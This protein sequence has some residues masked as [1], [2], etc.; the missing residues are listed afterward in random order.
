MLSWQHTRL[1]EQYYCHSPFPGVGHFRLTKYAE[2]TIVPASL[3]PLS[4]SGYGTLVPRHSIEH[5]Q[6]VIPNEVQH[7]FF[8]GAKRR[9]DP[10][11]PHPNQGTDTPC[12]SKSFITKQG[13]ATQATKHTPLLFLGGDRLAEANAEDNQGWLT[14]AP[15]ATY[16]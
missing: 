14:R 13:H 7:R 9:G 12:G 15:L 4:F 10:P 5:N 6:S 8:T 16:I 2:K 11:E 1:T 3:L